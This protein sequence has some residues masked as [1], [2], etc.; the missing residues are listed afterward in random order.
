MRVAFN[1]LQS[2]YLGNVTTTSGEARRDNYSS[3][4]FTALW[5]PVRQLTVTAT[6]QH[7]Q[8]ASNDSAFNFDAT[9]TRF[10]AAYTF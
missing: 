10:S 3:V 5:T 1:R 8:R 7:I 6:V 2:E 9:V 4:D